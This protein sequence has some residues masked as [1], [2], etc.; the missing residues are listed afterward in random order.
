MSI[1]KHHTAP[2]ARARCRQRPARSSRAARPR[3]HVRGRHDRRHVDDRCRCRAAQGRPVEPGDGRGVAAAAGAVAVREE[4]RA[5][6]EQSQ[7]RAS[8]LACPHAASSAQRHGH[9]QQPALHHLPLRPAGYRSRQA[10]AGHSRPGSAADG[11][12]GGDAVAVSDGRAHGVRRMRRQQRADVLQRAGPGQRP[13]A[14]WPRIQ[15]GVDRR[16]LV[17]VAGGDRHRPESELVARRRR[18][19][20]RIASQRAGQEGVGRRHGRALPERRAHHAR[21]RLSRC[22]CCCPATKAI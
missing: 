6:V 2:A 3:H 4:C 10:S 1:R 12:H 21:Q 20:R 19:L 16:P 18:R 9:A 22:A 17:H 15:C 5:D 13:G 14:A 7:Q 11:I 8:Q